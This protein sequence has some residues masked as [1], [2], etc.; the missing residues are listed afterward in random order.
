MTKTRKV[1]L[2][3]VM[4][5]R[6]D[7]YGGHFLD[8]LNY[9]ISN[10][11]NI[12]KSKNFTTEILIIEWNPPK[13]TQSLKNVIKAKSTK[14]CSIRIIT[15][16]ASIHNSLSNFENKQLLEFLAKNT[17]IRRARGEFV[18]CTNPDILFSSALLNLI[19][20]KKLKK[21]YF[22]RAIRYDVKKSKNQKLK[23]DKIMKYCENNVIRVL[24]QN[25][26]ERRTMIKIVPTYFIRAYRQILKTYRGLSFTP[27]DTPFTKAAGDFLLMSNKNWNKIGGYPEINGWYQ[28]DGLPIYQATFM[29]LKQKIFSYPAVIYHMDHDRVKYSKNRL[30]TEVSDA[31]SQLLSKKRFI[32]FNR[33]RWGLKGVQLPEAKL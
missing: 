28:I 22:Y 15:V 30:S 25:Y 12:L 20:P 11:L 17:G 7:N 1:F 5:A 18:L 3:V 13:G 21:N 10:L 14:K 33:K 26:S 8:R 32:K 4:S 9:S 29:G 2:S 31:Y 27:F 23:V 19:N 16:S 6:N 24:D